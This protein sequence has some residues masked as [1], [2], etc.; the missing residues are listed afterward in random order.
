MLVYGRT[1]KNYCQEVHGSSIPSLSA[2]TTADLQHWM[3]RFVLEARKKDGSEYPPESL[4][5]ICSGIVKHLH[6][7]GHPTLDIYRSSDFV[8]FC[9]KLD[10]E[11]KRLQQKGLGSQK[12]QAEPITEQEE[13]LLWSKGLLGDDSPQVLL[14]TMV[15]MIGLYFALQRSKEHRELRFSPSQIELVE[16]EGEW[17]YLFYTEDE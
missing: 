17:P 16:R 8:D 6:N 7:N 9:R 10:A 2:I 4:H 15:Y 11:M 13:E 1:G 12:Q 3:I 5:H 14:N